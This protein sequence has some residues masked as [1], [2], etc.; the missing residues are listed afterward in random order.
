MDLHYIF[1]VRS[2]RVL[3][4]TDLCSTIHYA[5]KNYQ[6]GFLDKSRFNNSGNLYPN[7]HHINVIC[8]S[9]INT[10]DELHPIIK[11]DKLIKVVMSGFIDIIG[12]MV[13]T[14]LVGG[15]TIGFDGLPLSTV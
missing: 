4:G 3:Y 8:K 1:S 14:V 11:F 7:E 10:P 6:V 15:Q 13:D 12:K 9:I 5:H 2:N